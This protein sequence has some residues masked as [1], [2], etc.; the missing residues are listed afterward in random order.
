MFYPE[1]YEVPLIIAG[2]KYLGQLA[3]ATVISSK[4]TDLLFLLL[5]YTSLRFLTSQEIR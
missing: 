5:N 1:I 3:D 4:Y 2:V